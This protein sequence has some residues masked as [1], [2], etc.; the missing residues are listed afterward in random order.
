[1]ELADFIASWALHAAS[2]HGTLASLNGRASGGAGESSVVA[3]QAD[4]RHGTLASLLRP[5]PAGTGGRSAVVHQ[6]QN[7]PTSGWQILCM[8][9]IAL[10]FPMAFLWWILS[11]VWK[12]ESYSRDFRVELSSRIAETVQRLREGQLWED[13]L[14]LWL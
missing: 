5:G 4:G 10:T 9:L 11:I 8:L 13:E 7:S 6:S 2:R 3:E 12:R 14:L 1:M